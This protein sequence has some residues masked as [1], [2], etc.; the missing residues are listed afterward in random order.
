MPMN[1]IAQW[2][3]N[4]QGVT[5]L[6]FKTMSSFPER[7]RTTRESEREKESCYDLPVNKCYR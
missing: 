4:Q 7:V 1:R 3:K 6:G 2:K 5:V